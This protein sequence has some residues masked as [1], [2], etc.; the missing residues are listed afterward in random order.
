MAG[1]TL[2]RH[3]EF[4][5]ASVVDLIRASL[6]LVIDDI[7]NATVN[8]VL[9][10]GAV[11]IATTTTKV[12]SV[13]TISFTV[14]GEFKSLAATDN[15][16]TL[17]G[18]VLAAGESNIWL[19]CVDAAG[20]A[21]VIEGTKATTVAGVVLGSPAAT[22]TVVG[23]VTVTCNS[24]TFTPGTTA[25]SAGTITVVYRNGIFGKMLKGYKTVTFK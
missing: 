5:D 20:A 18:G 25:L 23:A 1:T 17:T 21:S 6:N 11:A 15:F 2:T 10:S 3:A 16:W 19:L 12:K 4:V 9:S 22:V 8:A 14:D 24:A 13:A 7:Q